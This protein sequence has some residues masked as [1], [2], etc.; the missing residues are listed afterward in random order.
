M[1][2]YVN[3]KIGGFAKKSIIPAGKT[4]NIPE[5]T[6]ENQIINLGDFKRGFF[7]IIAGKP[8]EIKEEIKISKKKLKKDSLEKIEKEVRDYTEKDNK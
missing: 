4:V 3:Y 5:I 7:E 1:A 8:E 6:N 2:N